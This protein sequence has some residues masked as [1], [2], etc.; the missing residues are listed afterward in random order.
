MRKKNFIL[1]CIVIL[2]FCTACSLTECSRETTK[3][4]SGFI[5]VT[6]VTANDLQQVMVFGVDEEDNRKVYVKNF[7][8]EH[9]SIKDSH[10]EMKKYMNSIREY[11]GKEVEIRYHENVAGDYEIESIHRQ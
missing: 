2:L 6:G 1:P 4:G 11:V 5:T 10:R 3:K 8:N 7:F 9:D